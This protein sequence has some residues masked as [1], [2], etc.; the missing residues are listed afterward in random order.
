MSKLHLHVNVYSDGLAESIHRKIDLA[1]RDSAGDLARAGE[2]A[3]AGK[4]RASG[5]IDRANMILRLRTETRA[6]PA[7]DGYTGLVF[8]DAP[9]AAYQDRGVRGIYGGVGEY[10]Y[11]NNRP[12]LDPLLDWV[13]RNLQG[14][15][16]SAEGGVLVPA[17]D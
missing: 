15:R 5:A 8:N 7:G 1:L 4:I 9:Y 6:R 2:K 12:P 11:S 13:E 17:D 16:I 10:Q 14:W 3:A